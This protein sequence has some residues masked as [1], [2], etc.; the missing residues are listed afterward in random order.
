MSYLE[1]MAG[2]ISGRYS[3]SHPSWFRK[4][5]NKP[6]FREGQGQYRPSFRQVSSGELYHNPEAVVR[7]QTH[8]GIQVGQGNSELDE[9]ATLLNKYAPDKASKALQWAKIRLGQGDRKYLDDML[10]ILRSLEPRKW[11]PI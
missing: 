5:P 11:R 4:T 9:L 3:A 1:Y 10:Q 8:R 6:W 7:Q 2:R